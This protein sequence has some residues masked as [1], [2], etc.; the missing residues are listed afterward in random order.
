MRK[1]IAVTSLL[2][3]LP[4][5]LVSAYATTTPAQPTNVTV[6]FEGMIVHVLGGGVTR[7]IVPR[8]GDHQMTITLP[9]STKADVERIF[10]PLKCPSVCDV[11]IDGVAFR[12]VDGAGR[13]SP[14]PFV[15]GADFSAIVTRLS[16]VPS[17]Y[18][19]FEK[20]EDLVPEIFADA[21]SENNIVAGYFEL[22][23]GVGSAKAFSCTA[24]F[25]G[26][27]T[28][29][30]FPSRVDVA[31]AMKGGAKLQ[32]LK[33][34]HRDWETID[35][36]EPDVRIAVKNDLPNASMNHFDMYALLSNKRVDGGFVD[37]PEVMIDGGRCISAAFGVPGCSESSWP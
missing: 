8:L 22:G 4:L 9:A 21:P 18:R 23:G 1:K 12:I 29:S 32:V 34:G 17:P 26:Q 16:Q 33:A 15:A 11:P 3:L 7:A 28:P 25:E 36:R 19:P 31:Y 35:L 6:G 27:S 24:R 10:A 30:Q 5:F 13:P 14:K 2:L 20:K 37:L